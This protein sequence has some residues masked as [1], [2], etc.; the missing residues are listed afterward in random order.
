MVKIAMGAFTRVERLIRKIKN[1]WALRKAINQL[2]LALE[3]KRLY[4]VVDEEE[5][6]R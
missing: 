5:A 1:K 6:E 4:L 3:G 2:A